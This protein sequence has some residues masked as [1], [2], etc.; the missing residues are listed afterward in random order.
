M[1]GAVVLSKEKV[2]VPPGDWANPAWEQRSSKAASHRRARVNL[3]INVSL[4]CTVS[5]NVKGQTSSQAFVAGEAPAPHLSCLKAPPSDWTH[6]N[7]IRRLIERL[8]QTE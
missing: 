3:V 4:G 1:S 8:R 6:R 5:Q 2:N 7:L